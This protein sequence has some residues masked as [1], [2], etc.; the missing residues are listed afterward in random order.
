[1]F[2]YKAEYV[3]NYD[4]DTITFIIDL[5]FK[6]FKKATVRLARVD[7]KELRSTIQEERELALKA[8]ELVHDKL[9]KAKKIVL[10][11]KG[12]GK[13]GRYIAEV[14]FDGMNLSNFLLEQGLA[15]EYKEG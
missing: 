14:I 13:Y 3:S 4:G 11:V 15:D 8:K 1:M 9:S 5:G 6:V 12:K 10:H 2:I 7:T